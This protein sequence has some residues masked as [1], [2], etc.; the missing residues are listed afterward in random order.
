MIERPPKPEDRPA[1]PRHKERKKHKRDEAATAR[2]PRIPADLAPVVA[3]V[4]KQT[5]RGVA[6]IAGSLTENILA[7][8]IEER[9]RPLS[10]GQRKALF[11]PMAPLSTFSAKIEIGFA[12][13]LYPQ[14]C[15]S[16]PSFRG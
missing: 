12:I 8:I 16:P 9:F 4:M 6:I 1:S 13:G 7:E 11:D 10:R 14:T 15:G 5:P 2:K 3:E